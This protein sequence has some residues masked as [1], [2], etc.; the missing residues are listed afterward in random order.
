[1]RTQIIFYGIFGLPEVKMCIFTPKQ[2]GD[3]ILADVPS[4]REL[5]QA[6]QSQ[7]GKHNIQ[8]TTSRSNTNKPLLRTQK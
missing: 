1:M 7:G 6:T 8:N 2:R 3:T 4:L 5:K